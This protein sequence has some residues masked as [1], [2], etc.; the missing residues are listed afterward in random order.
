MPCL[1]LKSLGGHYL[2]RQVKVDL[3]VHGWHSCL[4]AD[5]HSKMAHSRQILILM[6]NIFITSN[7]KMFVQADKFDFLVHAT[8]HEQMKA[9]NTTNSATKDTQNLTSLTKLQLFLKFC[10]VLHRFIPNLSSVT[11]PATK[12]F[13][14]MS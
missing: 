9:S 3:R 1:F 6:R 14:S 8:C 4:L 10:N 7:L 2:I 13:A 11:D 12:H 5:I